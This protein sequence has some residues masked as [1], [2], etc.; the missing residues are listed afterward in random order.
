M[1]ARIKIKLFD[2]GLRF[3]KTARNHRILNWLIFRNAEGA[4]HPLDGVRCEDSHKRI[5]QRDKEL[6]FSWIT[7]TPRATT[8]LIV[9]ATRFVSFGTDDKESSA[10]GHFFP[11]N[12]SRGVATKLDVDA[13]PCHVGGD[14]HRSLLARLSDNLPFAFVIFGIENLLRYPL[15]SE[16]STEHFVLLHRDSSHQNRLAL[17]VQFFYSLGDGTHLALLSLKYEVVMVH[18]LW[19]VI[20]W[21]RYRMQSIYFEKFLRARERSACHS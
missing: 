4:H 5:F 21:H 8:Q 17:F 10:L 13:T 1:L 19:C 6:G 16:V 14:S 18:A 9:D 15:L 11:L 2:F 12:F 7:L 3:F 20:C